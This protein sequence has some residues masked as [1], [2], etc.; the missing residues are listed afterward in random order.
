MAKSPPAKAGAPARPPTKS[1]GPATRSVT[2]PGPA[3]F[4]H[5]SEDALLQLRIGRSAHLYT[6]LISA[7]LALDGILLLLF[8]SRLP[9]LP[10]SAVGLEA[11]NDT[12]F[13]LVPLGAGVA[14]ALIALRTKWE[15]FQLWPWEAHFS[16]TV[17]AV[18]LN[19]AIA[20]VYATRVTGVGP[21]ASLDLLPWFYPLSLFG[22]SVAL[23]GLVMTWT[24]WSARQWASALAAIFP[25]ATA[26]FLYLGM[27]TVVR[28]PSG[29]AISLFLSAIFYQTSGSFL[30][31]ISSGTRPHERELITSG[32]S[33]MFQFA[34]EIRGKAE[35]IHFRT[36]ALVKREADVENAEASLRRQHDSLEEARHQLDDF[37]ADYQVRSD[38]LIEKEHTW[39][40]R[41]AE[42]DAKTRLLDDRTRS[43]EVREQDLTRLV[44]QLSGREQR[45]VENE[46]KLTQRDVEVTQ[47]E[48]EAVR[49]SAA[50]TETETRLGSRQKELDRMTAELLRREGE[51]A[52][53][54]GG[55]PGSPTPRSD[56]QADLAGREAKLLQFKSVLDEQNVALGRKAKDLVEKARSAEEG[57]KRAAAREGTLAAR[58]ASLR[59]RESELEAA[60][61]AALERRAEY[62]GA[63]LGYTTR[64][65]EVRK[66]Q[67]EAAQKAADLDRSL[68]AIAEREKAVS[69]REQ[70]LQSERASLADRDQNLTARE[71]QLDAGEAEAGLWRA[72]RRQGFDLSPT[73]PGAAAGG[74]RLE[75]GVGPRKGRK[76]ATGTTIVE[77]PAEPATA[78][79][80]I[81]RPSFGT[82]QPDRRPSGIQRLDDLLL[83]GLPPRAHVVLLGDAFV[84]K[85][86]VLYSFIAEGLKRGEPALLVTGARPPEEV[87]AS[88]GIVLPQ[89]KEYEQLGMVTWID[90]SGA[91]ATAS[92]KRLVLSGP[93]DRAGILKNLVQVSKKLEEE[94]RS[95]FRVGFL[96]LSAVMT[97]GEANGGTSFLQNAVGILKLRDALAIYS[98]EGGAI[99]DAQV[100]ALLGRMDGAILFR[101]DRDKTFLSV[102]GLG[103]VQ[104]HDWV[105]CRAT[106]R[107]LVIG[108]F[109]LER[110]R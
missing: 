34:D 96:G 73:G 18:G 85:E 4:Q 75:G 103:E 80:G 58:E 25:V 32:Q 62:E 79:S 107:T 14:I 19:A 36:A 60:G 56:A 61:K 99:A 68:K 31:L 74:N 10:S 39:A 59:Q 67:T 97:G 38:A 35:A 63:T 2:V 55:G 6:V 44:P 29:L 89:F 81:L 108:S 45:L 17:G 47:R 104:T 50:L 24:T 90:A 49:R 3:D 53:R 46:G 88:L 21:F 87:A 65:E 1:L 37:E 69:V 48:Q 98:L 13:L 110:I 78:S 92:P 20:A 26:G 30:H 11:L 41:I 28:G 83:G 70:R 101:Q 106:N 15:A 22:V 93:S 91:G 66:L 9:V 72:E 64:L 105:E 95:P 16:T 102:K 82:K 84:G 57:A 109:A 52:S 51:V 23:L 77:V 71:R 94:H 33:K 27:I 42:M 43:L 7:A 8:V 5:A 12:A 76:L 40:G 54:E 86:I 100:E